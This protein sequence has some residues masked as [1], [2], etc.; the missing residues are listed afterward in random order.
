VL[1]RARAARLIH[2]DGEVEENGDI[3]PNFWWAEGGEAL[4]QNWKTGDF[5]TWIG[6]SRRLRA[7]GVTFWRSDIELS[8]AAPVVENTGSPTTSRAC[9]AKDGDFVVMLAERFHG[10]VRQIGNGTTVSQPSM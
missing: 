5:D 7:F 8:R 2:P 6:H 1:I 10:V 3:Q 9:G 4:D